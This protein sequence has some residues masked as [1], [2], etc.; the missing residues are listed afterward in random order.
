MEESVKIQFI[1]QFVQYCFNVAAILT[2]NVRELN[3]YNIDKTLTLNIHT[4]QYFSNILSMFCAVWVF[5][6][7]SVY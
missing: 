5:V 3:R 1:I 6:R 2:I 4:L 7:E